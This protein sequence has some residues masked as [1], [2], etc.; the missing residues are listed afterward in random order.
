MINAQTLN[1]TSST[2]AATGNM[3]VNAGTINNTG[4]QEQDIVTTRTYWNYVDAI[5]D[6]LLEAAAFNLRNS[7]TPLA[8]VEADLS[9]FISMLRG[10]IIQQPITTVTNSGSSYDAVIQLAAP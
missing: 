10:G 2:I 4:L 1:N 7:P 6:V 3:M 9:H 8:N 5:H